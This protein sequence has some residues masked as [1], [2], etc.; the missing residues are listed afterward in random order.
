MTMRI[1]SQNW[2]R[3]EAL[4]SALCICPKGLGCSLTYSRLACS[5]WSVSRRAF[6]SRGELHL[7]S[8]YCGLRERA[9]LILSQRDSF[10]EKTKNFWW[11]SDRRL[12]VPAIRARGTDMETPSAEFTRKRKVVE[13]IFL[14]TAKQDLAE[15]EER[16]MLDYLYTF[17]YHMRGII[18]ISLGR[19]AEQNSRGFTHAVFMRFQRKEDLERFYDNSYSGVLK[20]HVMPYCHGMI[21]MDFEAEVEDDILSIFRRGEDFN[22]GVEFMLLIQVVQSASDGPVEDVLAALTNLTGEFRSLIVQATQG[23]NFNVSNKEYTHALVIRF[24]SYD[25]L[26]LFRGSPEY[27]NVWRSKFQPLTKSSL[28]VYFSVDPVGTDI[29]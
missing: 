4:V 28:E 17:Q 24:P 23:R 7:K 21:S 15:H 29:M 2:V 12:I 26:K 9:L 18:A 5:S 14:L 3:H 10:G 25:A 19:I 27:R 20:E 1:H 11:P 6:G 22:Y 13:H 16:D 8:P